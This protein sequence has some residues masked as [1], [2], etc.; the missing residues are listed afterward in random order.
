[1][2]LTHDS[3]TS[4]L[5]FASRRIGHDMA[6][7]GHVLIYYN[8]LPDGFFQTQSVFHT[9]ESSVRGELHRLVLHDFTIK[10][11]KIEKALH[12]IEKM[13]SNAQIW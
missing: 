6:C 9:I 8:L 5:F 10:R 4:A 3:Y 13:S 2:F 7:L 1:M 11:Q 12:N